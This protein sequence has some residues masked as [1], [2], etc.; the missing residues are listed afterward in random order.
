M[1]QSFFATLAILLTSIFG[2]LHTSTVSNQPVAPS[3]PAAVV[4]STPSAPPPAPNVIAST[5][6]S[7]L[8]NPSSVAPASN[9][10]ELT[11]LQRAGLV[12]GTSTQATYVTQ[13]ELTTAISQLQSFFNQQ[14]YNS[15]ST[16]AY[17]GLWNAIAA[18]NRIDNLSGSSNGPL[19]ISDATFSNVSGLTAAEIPP[20]NYFPASSTIAIA[21][22]GTGTSTAPGA[23]QLML[24]DANGNWEYVATSSLGILNGITSSQWTTTGSTVSY[25]GGSVV[26]GTTTA[27]HEFDVWQSNNTPIGLTTTDPALTVTNAGSTLGNGSTV[28]FQGVDTSGTEVTLARISDISTS[29]TAGAASGNVAFYREMP[30]PSSKT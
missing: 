20:L 28:A 6:T 17:D 23:D 26:I 8:P 30:E 7:L 11:L 12:L 27:N 14:L 25:T 4:I 29:L 18:T 13:D 1:F 2:G 9:T 5:E 21:Y 16:D 19:T 3:Q 22:G 24:S 10:I 15:T